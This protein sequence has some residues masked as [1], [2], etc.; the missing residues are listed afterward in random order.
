MK[1]CSKVLIRGVDVRSSSEQKVNSVQVLVASGR[2]KGNLT[3]PVGEANVCPSI[4]QTTHCKGAPIARSIEQGST[5][6]VVKSI[7]LD[8]G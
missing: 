3:F 4:Q 7:H 5:A 6:P 1:W 8:L 2:E